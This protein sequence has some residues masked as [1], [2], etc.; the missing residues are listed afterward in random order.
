MANLTS[1]G[2]ESRRVRATRLME[3]ITKAM[4]NGATP[5]PNNV[6]HVIHYLVKYLWFGTNWTSGDALRAPSVV[7]FV[8]RMSMNVCGIQV[9]DGLRDAFS[10]IHKLESDKDLCSQVACTVHEWF[11]DGSK[12]SDEFSEIVTKENTGEC[13]ISTGAGFIPLLMSLMEK[14]GLKDEDIDCYLAPVV[15]HTVGFE[16]AENINIRWG[17]EKMAALHRAGLWGLSCVWKELIIHADIDVNVQDRNGKTPLMIAYGETLARY[18]PN[19]TH[20]DG[21]SVDTNQSQT[22][23]LEDIPRQDHVLWSTLQDTRHDLTLQDTSGRT[24]LDQALDSVHTAPPDASH[25]LHSVIAAIGNH[26]SAT[27]A[28]R[29]QAVRAVREWR[30]IVK[31]LYTT[32]RQLILVA[33]AIC[34]TGMCLA[35]MAGL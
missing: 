16:T 33:S 7:T 11:I 18:K 26:P 4:D 23:H 19:V 8:R 28:M 32:M 5:T 25:W 35:V 20:V 6:R 29:E 14:C 21:H 9:I 1:I 3:D 12:S 2:S 31:G 27:E 22:L 15:F 13:K 34:L 17:K 24:L 10:T 30:K